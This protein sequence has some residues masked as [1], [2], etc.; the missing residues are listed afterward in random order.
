MFG[1]GGAAGQCIKSRGQLQPT[2][3]LDKLRC[4]LHVIRRGAEVPRLFQ[5]GCTLVYPKPKT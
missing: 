4:A 2:S 5:L 1:G 3:L